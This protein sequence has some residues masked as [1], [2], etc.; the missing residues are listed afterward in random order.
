[1]PEPARPRRGEFALIA[2]LLAPL[3][4]GDHRALG[5]ADDAALLPQRSG[6]ETVVTTDTCVGGVHFWEDDPAGVI[7]SRLLRV[8]LSDLAAMAARPDAYFLN[9]VLP[10]WV[11]DQWLEEF[12]AGL[13]RDQALFGIR[14]LGGDVTRTGGPLVVSVTAVGEVPD[15]AAVRRSGARAGDL[16]L[17]SG[18]IGDATLG[19]L[20]KQQPS[21]QQCREALIQRFRTPE[22]RV[23]LGQN[24][25]GIATAMADVSDGLIAD[26]EHICSASA[27]SASICMDA[28]PLS[29]EVRT[30]VE[31][32]EIRLTDLLTGGD[33][34]ELVFAVPP[35][36]APLA[37]D[38][39]RK[40]GV[41][42][43]EIGTFT[44]GG[45]IVMIRA[46]D[47]RLVTIT[48]TGYRH[49]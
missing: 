19:R 47:G 30:A 2:E 11:G 15:G 48:E 9:L 18:T 43:T 42:V 10:D 38:A 33:D 12:A 7:A 5:F 29:P 35:E 21:G 41:P 40:A 37:R 3:G 1:M 14:L 46:S 13:G 34:Y 45:G 4:C 17:V 25:S 39:G 26:I 16:V 27:V 20:E 36:F 44:E 49:F 8:N 32:G 23:Q 28:V 22:P 31:D 24:L 6:L